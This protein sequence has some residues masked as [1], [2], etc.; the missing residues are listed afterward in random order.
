[1][2]QPILHLRDLRRAGQADGRFELTRSPIRIGRGPRCEIRLHSDEI[3]DVQ[4][5]LRRDGQR[6]LIHPVGPADG[7]RFN[8]EPLA[9]TQNLDLGTKFTIGHV[10]LTLGD[11]QAATR[12]TV[13]D[14]K[15]VIHELSIPTAA[16][17]PQPAP[18]P[19]AVA[20]AAPVLPEPVAIVEPVRPVA[21]KFDGP[22]PEA[23]AKPVR[24]TPGLEFEQTGL[25][26]DLARRAL[27]KSHRRQ[28]I[29]TLTTPKAASAAVAMAQPLA[30]MPIGRA[31][32][33]LSA[34]RPAASADAATSL[35]DWADEFSRRYRQGQIPAR[36][37]E[38]PAPAAVPQG[39][40][41]H[42]SRLFVS[43]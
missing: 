34:K 9:E 21:A 40:S 12:P 20:P 19:L 7:C 42:R 15:P 35:S 1:M 13:A 16:P 26:A 31:M 2:L 30:E 29:P 3:A 6:W 36:T 11:A 38:T 5:I 41:P 24:H 10:E 18:E 23:A 4:V 43:G 33:T 27:E 25:L 14:F 17:T 39:H 22:A 8:G 32:P 28:Q 37:A